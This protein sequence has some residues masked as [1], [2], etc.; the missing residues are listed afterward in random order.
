M[1]IY[2]F[3]GIDTY[4]VAMDWLRGLSGNTGTV[5]PNFQ[6]IWSD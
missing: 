4:K 6:S 1:L 5:A 3:F 2:I